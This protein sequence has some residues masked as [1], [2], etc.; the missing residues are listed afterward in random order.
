MRHLK[1]SLVSPGWRSNSAR[2]TLPARRNPLPTFI[3][4]DMAFDLL[5][6]GGQGWLRLVLGQWNR[7]L[8]EARPDRVNELSLPEQTR[9]SD[10]LVR[11]AHGAQGFGDH[12]DVR[13]RPEDKVADG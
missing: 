2:I 8:L 6:P 4:L 7:R 5:R 3:K 9:P 13:V 12:V 1:R 10:H 11:L